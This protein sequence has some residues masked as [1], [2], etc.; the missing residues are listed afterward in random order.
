M[1]TNDDFYGKEL[2][3]NCFYMHTNFGQKYPKTAIVG[4]SLWALASTTLLVCCF[5]LELEANLLGW[6]INGLDTKLEKLYSGL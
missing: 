3:L 2:N 6:N 1:D 4:S 5:Q